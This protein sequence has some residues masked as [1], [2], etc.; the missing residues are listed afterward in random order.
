MGEN[1]SCERSMERININSADF[2]V[3]DPQ[4]GLP[5]QIKVM[6]MSIQPT[7]KAE[8]LLFLAWKGSNNNSSNK[9]LTKATIYRA[10]DVIWKVY[11]FFFLWKSLCKS[12]GRKCVCMCACMCGCISA[13][14]GR[15]VQC[16][17]WM[18]R[19]HSPR[20]HPPCQPFYRPPPKTER[21]KERAG[22]REGVAELLWVCAKQFHVISA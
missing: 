13:R 1:S 11:T 18:V 17:S 2:T 7:R 4:T 15:Q 6:P 12:V 21:A 19:M 22:E 10:I 3:D 5:K 14:V 8:K 9:Q 20:R 16:I